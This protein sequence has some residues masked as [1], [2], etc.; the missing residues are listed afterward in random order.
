MLGTNMFY[1]HTFPL[2]GVA[3]VDEKRRIADDVIV[4]ARGKGN[5][6]LVNATIR[7]A[8]G[9]V[10]IRIVNNQAAE[11]SSGVINWLPGNHGLYVVDKFGD[12]VLRLDFVN[13]LTLVVAK[14]IF[15]HPDFPTI[16][17]DP[18]GIRVGT[19]QAIQGRKPD[20]TNCTEGV[21]RV[22]SDGM[23]SYGPPPQ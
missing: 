22:T 8:D 4:L 10:V 2:V 14:G 21:F 3:F 11:P 6:L 9:S 12:E 23:A 19:K 5:S 20:S 15:R 1:F 7:A 13:P 16:W 18:D 17:V